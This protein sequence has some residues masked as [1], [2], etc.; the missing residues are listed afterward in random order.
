VRSG[1][2][3]D[4]PWWPAFGPKV[5]RLGIHSALSLPLIY[6]GVVVGAMNIYGRKRDAFDDRAVELGEL[7]AIP[8]AVSVHNAQVLDRARRLAAQL[9]AALDGRAVIDQAAGIL[10][11]RTGCDVD[12]ALARMRARSQRENRKLPAIAAQIVSTAVHRAR[13]RRTNE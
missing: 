12:E 2:L 10:M 3:G 11:S 4:E 13:S 1:S 8:A 6:D 9:Q 5:A 7:Y